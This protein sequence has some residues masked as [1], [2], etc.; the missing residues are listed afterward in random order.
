MLAVAGLEA[1]KRMAGAGVAVVPCRAVEREAATGCVRALARD[2]PSNRLL[3]HKAMP[4]AP[5]VA[6]FRDVISG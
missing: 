2:A 1:L 6:L 5:S 3:W 4:P